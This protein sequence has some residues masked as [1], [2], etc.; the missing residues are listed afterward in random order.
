VFA[1]TGKR[2]YKLPIKPEM[3]KANQTA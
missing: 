2:V 3:L 1:A